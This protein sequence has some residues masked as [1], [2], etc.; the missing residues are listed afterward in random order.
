MRWLRCRWS[1]IGSCGV[2]GYFSRGVGECVAVCG[3]GEGVS[4][5][6]IDMTNTADQEARLRRRCLKEVSVSS[7]Q[8][9]G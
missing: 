3:E 2:S 4:S 9:F 1:W 6:G 7:E 5:K 8:V